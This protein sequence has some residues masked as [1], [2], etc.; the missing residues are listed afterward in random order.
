MDRPTASLVS[1]Q[2]FRAFDS[3]PFGYEIL[4]QEHAGKEFGGI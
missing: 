3:S 4:V 1:L 2:L